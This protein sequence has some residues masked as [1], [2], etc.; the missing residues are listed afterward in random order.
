LLETDVS[1]NTTFAN[2]EFPKVDAIL[3][4]PFEDAGA[5]HSYPVVVSMSW[6]EIDSIDSVTHL[7]Q[8]AKW[9]S[10]LRLQELL[11]K[12]MLTWWLS[13]V[14]FIANPDGATSPPGG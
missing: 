7:P 9:R 6:F 8:L 11:K 2:G 13:V 5:H 14:H 12:D 10:N 1:S 3:I 4:N